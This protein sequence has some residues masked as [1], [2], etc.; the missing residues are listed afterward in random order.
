M[1][2]AELNAEL[3]KLIAELTPGGSQAFCESL[4]RKI[5]EVERALAHVD[6]DVREFPQKG[7]RYE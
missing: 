3:A 2:R 7:K 6:G 5:A 4:R 1:T